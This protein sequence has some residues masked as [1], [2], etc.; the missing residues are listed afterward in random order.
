GFLFGE[1]AGPDETFFVADLEDVVHNF[2]I[3]GA[4]EKIF[5]DAFDYVGEGLAGFSSFHFFVVERANRVHADYF[6]VGILFLKVAADARNGAT[7]ACAADEVGDFSFGVSP[8]F[9]AGGAVM[10]LGVHGIFVL[11]GIVG[12]GNF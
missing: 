6:D 2:Q 7:G 11:V 3:H 1:T 10:R 9:W 12:I 4:R 8:D 5:T